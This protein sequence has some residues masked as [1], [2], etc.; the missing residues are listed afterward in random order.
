M[1][2]SSFAGGCLGVPLRVGLSVTSP[3]YAVGFPLQS[4]TWVKGLSLS[5]ACTLAH[6]LSRP[7]VCFRPFRQA[8]W[9]KP[10]IGTEGQTEHVRPC[11]HTGAS[12]VRRNFPCPVPPERVPRRLS[13]SRKLTVL[14]YTSPARISL[15]WETGVPGSPEGFFFPHPAS[16]LPLT[17]MTDR[18]F[19]SLS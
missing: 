18:A 8:A 4:L 7:G 10:D 9:L 6:G 3:R 1:L 2:K 14:P 16:N 19:F 15:P 17:G 11:R 5:C 12:A 13:G